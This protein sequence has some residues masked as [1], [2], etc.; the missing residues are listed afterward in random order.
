MG[1]LLFVADAH[2]TRDDPE[3]DAFVSFLA[4]DARRASTLCILGDL[5]NLWFGKPRFALPHHDRVLGA[6]EDLRGRGVRLLYVEGN[7]DFHLRRN[8]L[9]RPFDDV[10]EDSLVVEHA[11]RRIAAA[12]GDAINVQ[13]RQYRAWKSFSKSTPVYGAFSMLPGSWGMALGEALERK[14]SGTNLRHRA[15]FPEEH[16]RAYAGRFFAEGSEAL[17][18]GHFHEERRIDLGGAGGAARAV[19]V[20][21]AWRLGHRRLVVDGDGP[22]RFEGPGG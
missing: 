4:G 10:A 3:V 21:P 1:P 13:D 19:Y 6:L 8:H 20:L 11:G 2:L 5:F 15:R 14:L 9:G 7:R 16:C 12:H 22:P 17:V 18:L